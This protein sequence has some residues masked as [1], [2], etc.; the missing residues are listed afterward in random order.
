MYLF[1]FNRLID[2]ICEMPFVKIPWKAT[3]KNKAKQCTNKSKANNKVK[4]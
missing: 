2:F 4:E 3:N 1:L